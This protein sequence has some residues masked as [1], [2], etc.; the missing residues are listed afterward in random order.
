MRHEKLSWKKNS[1]G[2]GG[3]QSAYSHHQPHFK[4]PFFSSTYFSFLL[5][6]TM[7]YGTRNNNNSNSDDD[8]DDAM[9]SVEMASP[10][11]YMGI[12]DWDY[13]FDNFFSK[14][15]SER[16]RSCQT[17]KQQKQCSLQATAE[18]AD[19][20]KEDNPIT[21]SSSQ[22]TPAASSC[23]HNSSNNAP[24]NDHTSAESS[25]SSSGSPF[26]PVQQQETT[27]AAAA[28]AVVETTAQEDSGDNAGTTEGF[29]DFCG[30][31]QV[32]DGDVEW[33]NEDDFGDFAEFDEWEEDKQDT[34][35]Q[36][37]HDELLNAWSTVLT[38]I[39]LDDKRTD[40]G[41]RDEWVSSHGP[42]S[43]RYYVLEEAHESVHSKITWTSV[44][45]TMDQDTGV[46]R[47]RWP[48]SKIENMYLE[49]LHCERL[50]PSTAPL[51]PSMLS[52]GDKHDTLS[53]DD[54][55][56]DDDASDIQPAPSHRLSSQEKP[57]AP[58]PKPP[59][60]PSSSVKS[61]IFGFSF[62]KFL[63][64]LS[65]TSLPRSDSSAPTSA[66]STQRYSLESI[67]RTSDGTGTTSPGKDHSH[68]SRTSSPIPPPV[69]AASPPPPI[70][71]QSNSAEKL[72]YL[73]Q[74]QIHLQNQ[75]L[76]DTQK[77]IPE[78]RYSLPI[79]SSS[80][81][82]SSSTNGSPWNTHTSTLTASMTA[83]QQQ[84]Q[85][86]RRRPMTMINTSLAN[87]SFS[88]LD[89]DDDIVSTPPASSRT[90]SFTP[91]TPTPTRATSIPTLIPKKASEPI[92]QKDL[93]TSKGGGCSSPAA[94]TTT[95]T[96]SSTSSSFYYQDKDDQEF[97]EFAGSTNDE[98]GDFEQADQEEEE[99]EEEWGDWNGVGSTT[100]ISSH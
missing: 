59:T 31:E 4:L 76:G 86:Q 30:G 93:H 56:D 89:L 64:R 34:H 22:T 99:E 21:S 73:P 36:Q 15:I 20:E 33:S 100:A 46:P 17:S 69:I 24:K 16:R 48:H 37:Q 55:D 75:Y 49:A 80:S 1:K 45:Y 28:A 61:P 29:S 12:V 85:Q 82:S 9:D 43:I 78:K 32:E 98:F 52:V 74:Q 51:V 7:S 41:E 81:S 60:T 54:D 47:V 90:F 3:Q 83:E 40:T 11:C 44:T 63:P 2:E 91:L 67:P 58:S 14:D 10:A 35:H 68:R 6:R 19:S 23:T 92:Q 77:A 62:S 87:K 95:T 18:T 79:S 97:G 57:Q 5:L 26:G 70:L 53:D 96:T 42:K 27:A 13:G 8:D 39:C 25:S 50:E 84:Q 65:T 66:T 72:E 88:I 38:Q 71:P 94:C